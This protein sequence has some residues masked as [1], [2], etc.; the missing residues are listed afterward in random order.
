[1]KVL[2]KNPDD[3]EATLRLGQLYLLRGYD[4]ALPLSANKRRDHMAHGVFLIEKVKST[5]IVAKAI[6]AESLNST[7][8]SSKAEQ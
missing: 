8:D 5:S 6:K 2:S 7:D 4:L 3:D 1:M